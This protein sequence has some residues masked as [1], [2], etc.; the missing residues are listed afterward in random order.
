[1]KS[2]FKRLWESHLKE[3]IFVFIWGLFLGTIIGYGCGTSDRT[4]EL[5]CKRV[6]VKHHEDEAKFFYEKWREEEPAHIKAARELERLKSARKP[7]K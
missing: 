2:I 3:P 4:N 1:M 5:A 6:M 7:Q